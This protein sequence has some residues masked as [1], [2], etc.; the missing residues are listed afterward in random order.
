MKRFKKGIAVLCSMVIAIILLFPCAV[1]KAK[2]EET[3]TANLTIH[4]VESINGCN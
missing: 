3:A 2:A 4:F 1:M